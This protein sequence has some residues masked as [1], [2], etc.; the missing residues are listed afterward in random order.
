MRDE[1]T[2]VSTR[3]REGDVR[4]MVASFKRHLRAGNVSEP[5][6]QTYL[7]SCGF[8][9]VFEPDRLCRPDEYRRGSPLAITS[10]RH[11]SSKSV[12]GRKLAGGFDSRPPPLLKM[13]V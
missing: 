11:E 7:E 2:S 3:Q 4:T 5:T 9:G 8:V 6:I 1:G 13:A 10:R 12:G